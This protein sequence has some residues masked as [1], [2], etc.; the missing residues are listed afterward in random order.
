M[1]YVIKT[2]DDGVIETLDFQG[3]TFVK[4]SKRKETGSL[5][6]GDEDFCDQLAASGQYNN[7]SFLDEVYDLVDSN[8]FAFDLLQFADDWE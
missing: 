8:F 7:D 5:V 1:K 3:E 2:T 4:R 6:S